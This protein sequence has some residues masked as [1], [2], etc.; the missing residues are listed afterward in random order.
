[1]NEA[2]NWFEIKKQFMEL[3]FE[4][5]KKADLFAYEAGVKPRTAQLWAF[6]ARKIREMRKAL[7]EQQAT[8]TAI[9]PKMINC[10]GCGAIYSEK[11]PS[12]P[13]CGANKPS[14]PAPELTPEPGIETCTELPSETKKQGIEVIDTNIPLSEID[15]LDEIN[16]RLEK[17][18]NKKQN[19]DEII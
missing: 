10:P 12:C 15:D 7:S 19:P 11:L 16:K 3:Y 4:N 8:S 1:M 18:M 14:E 9:K 2:K 5:P 17:L 6:Q 13:G